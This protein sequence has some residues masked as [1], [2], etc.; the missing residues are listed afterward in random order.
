MKFLFD[1]HLPPSLKT[2][3]KNSGFAVIHTTDLPLKNETSDSEIIDYAQLNDFIVVTK[4]SDF[5]FS[6]IISTKPEKLILVK[7]GNIGKE[8]LKIIFAHFLKDIIEALKTHSLVEL[9]K[10]IIVF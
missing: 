10:D 1:A 6:H 4:D 8:Q 5:Y 7:I 3:F 2:V 9:H